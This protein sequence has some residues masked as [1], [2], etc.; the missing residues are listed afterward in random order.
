MDKSD[1]REL[2]EFYSFFESYK[3]T[4]EKI[5]NDDLVKNTLEFYKEIILETEFKEDLVVELM[6]D[7][8]KIRENYKKY[9]YKEYL[10]GDFNV[11]DNSIIYQIEEC[12][13]TIGGARNLII[14]KDKD[15][16]GED[17]VEA[18][19]TIVDDTGKG[20]LL[21]VDNKIEYIY[22][23][24]S[25]VLYDIEEKKVS[26]TVI[27]LTKKKLD[28]LK[29]NKIDIN[30]RYTLFYA[31][32]KV[33]ILF[34][35]DID[36]D[37]I[38]GESPFYYLSRLLMAIKLLQ[39]GLKSSC[40][41]KKTKAE[42]ALRSIV[43]L[44]DVNFYRR[45]YLVA[46]VKDKIRGSIKENK[47]DNLFA[48][49]GE[50]LKNI[51]KK[52]IEKHKSVLVDCFKLNLFI[53]GKDILNKYLQDYRWGN[54]QIETPEQF[55]KKRLDITLST[56]KEYLDDSFVMKD[57][58]F[59]I[60][61]IKDINEIINFDFELK[62][63]AKEREEEIKMMGSIDYLLYSDYSDMEEWLKISKYLDEVS[64]ILNEI[65]ELIHRFHEN[66]ISRNL[67]DESK[68]GRL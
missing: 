19:D 47:M 21:Y 44:M 25:G 23:S 46:K 57:N 54:I 35:K 2:E 43:K 51:P 53:E 24:K 60:N 61:F 7:Y 33:I 38:F 18:I 3:F 49:K 9:K 4:A 30:S 63:I 58:K 37:K 68:V 50:Q 65:K 42:S 39:G 59:Y 48:K 6:L 22:N 29:K 62:L 8:I 17:V 16:N 12:E 36:M 55:F 13:I 40:E 34:L 41:R 64:N 20:M 14:Y 45:V 26:D 15:K 66:K 5:A 52:L 67:E 10:S 11:V 56:Y 28:D 31:D 32:K 1:F 27:Q